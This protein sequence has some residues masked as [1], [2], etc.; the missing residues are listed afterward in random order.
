MRILLADD[1]RDVRLGLR[2]ILEQQPGL[3]IVAETATYEEM[4]KVL[5]QAQPDIVI[6]DWELP[7][8]N[9]L[10]L[11]ND[12]RSLY[13]ELKVIALSGR[14]ES[15]KDALKSGIDAFVCKFDQPEKLIEAIDEVC[16]KGGGN[17]AVN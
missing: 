11:V 15:K 16:E 14:P 7:D 13:P 9:I 5:K 2:V 17:Y 8:L 1:Q 4:Q 10:D 6:L 12:L 3:E